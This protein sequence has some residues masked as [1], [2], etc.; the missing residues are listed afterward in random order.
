LSKKL[1]FSDVFRRKT[2]LNNNT[3]TNTNNTNK[4]MNDDD[5]ETYNSAPFVVTIPSLKLPKGTR[6]NFR[7]GV[8][9]ELVFF[10]TPSPQEKRPKTDKKQ[11]DSNVYVMKWDILPDEMSKLVNESHGVFLHLQ[12]HVR[13]V[14]N[15]ELRSLLL[16]SS[17]HYRACLRTQILAVRQHGKALK[18]DARATTLRAELKQWGRLC[19][20]MEMLWHL[21][22]ILIIA[23]AQ[24]ELSLTPSLVDWLNYHFPLTIPDLDAIGTGPK[25]ELHHDYWPLFYRLLLYGRIAECRDLLRQHSQYAEAIAANITANPFVILDLLLETMPIAKAGDL[26]LEDAF[27]DWKRWHDDV[28]RVCTTP[29]VTS[30][31]RE[32]RRVLDVLR[33]DDNALAD[34]TN[35]WY[36][37]AIAKFLFQDPFATTKALHTRTTTGNALIDECLA[38]KQNGYATVKSRADAVS[39]DS[40]IN[41][42]LLHIFTANVRALLNKLN[43]LS[44]AWLM[45][46]FIDLLV[47]NNSVTPFRLQSGIDEREHYLLEYALSLTYNVRVC[48]ERYAQHPHPGYLTVA[49]DYLYHAP[50]LG[51]HHLELYVARTAKETERA[52]RNVLHLCA[53]YHLSIDI[54]QC[55]FREMARRAL[56]QGNL[57]R[58]AYWL[59]ESILERTATTFGLLSD[60]TLPSQPHHGTALALLRHI[61]TLQLRSLMTTSRRSLGQSSLEA[62]ISSESDNLGIDIG[63]SS[64]QFYSLLPSSLIERLSPTL[65]FL[66]QYHDFCL[67][68]ARG[69]YRLASQTLLHIITSRTVPTDY[70]THVFCNDLLSLLAISLSS[71]IP[72]SSLPFSVQDTYELLHC[73]EE[74]RLQKCDNSSPLVD[75]V[76][77]A[78]TRYL[79]LV[80][81]ETQSKLSAAVTPS[82]PPVAAPI[83]PSLRSSSPSYIT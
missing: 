81:R 63:V 26:R 66:R 1:S 40:L 17:R 52:A 24:R 65:T 6:L 42:L 7:W 47:K 71:A 58:A 20:V 14:Q 21:A 19:G 5:D 54:A 53:R 73:F 36:E 70:L 48:E 49:A 2:F 44:N 32:L 18:G 75:R 74:W 64:P 55:I 34:I 68:R 62:E 8:G 83:V 33:G 78:L 15:D 35:T 29:L 45:A 82:P 43:R 56:R 37:L 59:L 41:G 77:A 25:P 22:E 31:S 28:E 23:P 76:N 12:Q 51:K 27:A 69:E 3:N 46:H 80:I 13:E 39:H 9:N 30:W 79:A 60:T 38:R 4:H 10:I 50:G 61:A 57:M 72:T 16:R 67:Q 11:V